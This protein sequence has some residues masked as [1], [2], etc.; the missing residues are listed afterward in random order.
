MPAS[1]DPAYWDEQAATFDA[2][3]DHG[4]SAGDTREAWRTCLSRWLPPLPCTVADL[5][6]GTGSL[7]LLAAELGHRAIGVDFAEAM[8][9]RARAKAELA[10][11]HVRYLRGDASRP[12]LLPGIADVILLRHVLWALPDPVGAVARWADLM[13][14]GGSFVLIE[15]RWSTGSGLRWGEV[16][17][18]LE[19][20][21][22]DVTVEELTDPVLWGGDIDD[23]RYVV[24]GSLRS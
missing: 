8:V 3:P 20:H 5:G 19:T 21:C 23:Q 6:C 1:N 12:P 18:L 15:G 10:N 24:R 9:E 14:A 22:D 17:A 13:T 4:L 7:T 16:T 11:V 2:E